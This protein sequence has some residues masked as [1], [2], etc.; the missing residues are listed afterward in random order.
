MTTKMLQ[1]FDYFKTVN[2]VYFGKNK[3]LKL[4]N[5]I[6]N[7]KKNY[8][9]IFI[10]KFF[11]EKNDL[12]K[13]K[14]DNTDHIFYLDTSTEPTTELVDKIVYELKEIETSIPDLIVG[15][16]GGS[17]L[18]TAKAVSN[19]LTN[20]GKA[21]T[22]QG[23]DLITNKGIYKV[24]IPTLSG[25][26]AEATRTCVLINNLNGLKLGMNS[27]HTVFDEIIL[28]PNLTATVDKDQFFYSAMDTF[29]H[30]IESLN[31]VYRNVLADNF[32]NQALRLSTEALSSS[33]IL[34]DDS[35]EKIMIASYL[36][37]CAISLSY[38]G[39]I[40]PLSAALSVVFKTP[41]CLANCIVMRAMNKYYQKEFNIFWNLVE[42]NN[43]Y[44]PKGI[45]KNSDINEFKRLINST[46]IHEKPLTNYF[47]ENFR[48][49]LTDDLLVDIFKQM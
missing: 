10:D 3:I 21:S 6:K 48:K 46:I 47:G 12:L 44:I 8:S 31:G 25:T 11:K 19:L 22:Y 16:G 33:K 13:I 37:G 43:I 4:E 49:H 38:V 15:I 34:D 40:H 14:F 18:D 27:P 1:D 24:G 32:S 9:I 17:T 26:G 20:P 35:R 41:H 5:I 39:L 28:D 2:K 36:G 42:K 23:W 45:C 7:K 29:I 30:S